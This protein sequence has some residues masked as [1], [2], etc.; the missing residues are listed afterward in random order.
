MADIS[1]YAS[2][3]RV[4]TCGDELEVHLQEVRLDNI[5]AEFSV[6]EILEELDMS[7]IVDFAKEHLSDED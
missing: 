1:I 6:Q 7:D 2:E 3:V 4:E 5:L